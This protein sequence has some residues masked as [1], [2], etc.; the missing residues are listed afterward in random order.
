MQAGEVIWLLA[1]IGIGLVAAMLI[2]VGVLIV[3]GRR[4]RSRVQVGERKP[5]F[6]MAA[7]AKAKPPSARTVPAVPEPTRRPRDA[8][9]T[10]APMPAPERAETVLA[11]QQRH[12]GDKPAEPS[13]ALP[14]EM[15]S[16][17]ASEIARVQVDEPVNV[18]AEPPVEP[19]R[20]LAEPAMPPPPP[21][22]ASEAPA[23]TSPPKPAV[24]VAV[25]PPPPDARPA[26]KV[27]SLPKV[28][29]ARKFAPAL[30]PRTPP[31]GGK[32]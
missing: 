8:R 18:I 9:P 24:P 29:P 17:L 27:S 28:T 30:P 31:A 22:P 14:D 1:G 15:M 12:A 21:E 32:S 16:N 13:P 26:P 23:E 3:D 4:L 19:V 2:L 7:T 25:E 20:A 5:E 11:A 6:P 10:L